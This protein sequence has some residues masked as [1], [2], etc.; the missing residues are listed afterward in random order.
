MSLAT[1]STSGSKLTADPRILVCEDDRLIALGWVA[2]LE[3][4]GYTVVGPAHSAETAFE[5]AYQ[6]LP[7]L[8][9]IDIN[10]SGTID[11]ISVAAELAP[12]GVSIIFIT[13][14]YNRAGTEG[15]E[16]AADILIKPVMES[17][18]LKA[19]A[20]TLQRKQEADAVRSA[21]SE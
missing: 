14:H 17:T 3:S 11:G 8:A 7:D 1:T 4:G 6:Y 15:R 16:F 12:L 5:L 18:V 10:L 9:L 21:L 19:V 20:A 2:L 13:A